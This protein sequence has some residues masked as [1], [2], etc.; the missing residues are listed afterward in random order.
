MSTPQLKEE[1]DQMP[2]SEQIQLVQ[3][4]WDRIAARP[5]AVPVPPSHLEELRRRLAEHG[6]SP[7]DVVAWD[8][9]KAELRSRE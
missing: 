7:D 5:E 2:A 3:E 6:Q 8:D 9:V 4:L 1:F